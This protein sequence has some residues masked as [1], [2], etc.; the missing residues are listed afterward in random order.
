M[1]ED[2]SSKTTTVERVL[3]S[4]HMG[5]ILG[6]GFERD[7]TVTAANGDLSGAA[8]LLSAMLL[9]MGR[10]D[11][12]E[13]KVTS[14]T[15]Q[16]EFIEGFEHLSVHKKAPANS[17][18]ASAAA[19]AGG[20]ARGNGTNQANSSGPPPA[21]SPS[22]TGAQS[23]PAAGSSA[24]ARSKPVR[25][26]TKLADTGLRIGNHALNKLYSEL[27]KLNVDTNPHIGAAMVRVFFEKA[28]MVFLEDMAV[29]CRNPNG[30]RDFNVKL[31]DKT[32]AAL[33]VVDAGKTNPKLQYVW[34]IANGV[35]GK[36]H[37]LD[38]LNRA[39][40][41][42]SALPSASEI[43]G[44]WDRYHDYFKLIFETLEKNGK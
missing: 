31:K 1:E 32:A 37:T 17:T 38:Q 2:I 19:A 7:G 13:T 30:W 12:T 16:K 43:V 25:Q 15:L 11:F 40:H 26:R 41:D 8:S 5:S 29:P 44:I 6:V 24:T 34:E 36:L 3:T 10:P 42:H 33:N 23:Q 39:I 21:G 22:G 27:K 9:A 28:T 4:S 20:Q 14:A 18:Q 35:Q